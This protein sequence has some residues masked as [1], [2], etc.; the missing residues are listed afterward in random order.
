MFWDKVLNHYSGVAKSQQTDRH[1]T[2]LVTSE[3]LQ[4]RNTTLL[5]KSVKLNCGQR[6]SEERHLTTV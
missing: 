2:G 6:D 5:V 3:R 1:R 4:S